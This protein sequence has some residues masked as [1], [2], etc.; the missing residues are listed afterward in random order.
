MCCHFRILKIAEKVR[1][2]EAGSGYLKRRAIRICSGSNIQYPICSRLV[3]KRL[4]HWETA[5]QL[6]PYFAIQKVTEVL[7][8]SRQSQRRGFLTASTAFAA[9][10]YTSKGLFADLLQS[11][12]L[13]EGP[14]YPDHLPL[15]LDND[16]IVLGDSLTPAI[17]TITHLSGRILSRSGE[18]LR[19]ITVEIW[20]CDANAVY[21]HSRDSKPKQKQ[22]DVHFQGFG[23]FETNSEGEYR[24]RTIKPVPYP[25]RPAPHIHFKIK[26]GDREL[27]T[28]Q[29]MIRGFEGNKNDGIFGEAGDAIDRE[30][31]QTDFLPMPDSKIAELIANFDIV[32][33]RTPEDKH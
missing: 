5:I 25:G 31:I 12:S 30:L 29:L 27:L 24:F 22:Q 4:A 11:P 13:T 19:G 1:R 15:D 26:S 3:P 28:T 17:G 21:L 14:F 8:S 33:G 10:L 9:S 20:Q 7:F 18:P 6:S 2:N 16:L 32:L 23:R